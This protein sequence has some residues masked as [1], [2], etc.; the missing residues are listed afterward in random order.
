MWTVIGSSVT[1]SVTGTPVAS[2]YT[3]AQT[4]TM[5]GIDI[6]AASNADLGDWSCKIER[7]G[8]TTPVVWAKGN[9]RRPGDDLLNQRISGNSIPSHYDL[10][11]IALL[12]PELR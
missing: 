10:W 2:E 1:D 7:I 8:G 3:G 6:S 12:E 5:C 9:L 4:S 11:F